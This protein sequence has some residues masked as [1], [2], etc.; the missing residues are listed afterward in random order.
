MSEGEFVE[1]TPHKDVKRGPQDVDES[2]D[3]YDTIDWLVKNIPHNNGKVGTY[4]ISYPGFYAAAGILDAH[5]AHKAASPQ[6][7]M[8]D[9]FMG[10]DSYHGG[11]FMLSANFGFYT[12]F[13]KR[14]EP[15]P[16][17]TRLPFDFKTPN[18]Y[19]FYL[20]MGSL[21]NGIENQMK[22]QSPYFNDTVKHWTY[23]EF[24]KSRALA[25]HIKNVKP[26]V[27]TVGGWFDHEDLAGPLTL[28]RA[29]GA[30]SPDTVNILVEGPWAHGGWSRGDGDVLGNVRFD[31]KTGVVF[32]DDIQFPF[33][34][35]YLK[36]KGDGKFP[37]AYVFETG[38]NVWR[39]TDAWPPKT[40]VSKS[41]YLQAGGKLDFRA[42]T[43][44]AN[45]FDE[46]VSDP[47][48]PV[49][50]TDALVTNVPGSYM[51]GDQRF[52]STRTDVM[53][54]QTDPLE[55]DMTIAGLISPRLFVSTSGTDSDW[56]VKL[57]DVYPN[58]YPDPEPNPTNVK[59]GGYQQLIR[60]EPL[61]G[62]FR[63]SMERPE[64][65]TPGKM[66]EIRF[67]M[68]DV[69]HTFRR[70]HRVMVQVQSSWFPLV[71]RNPQKF[72]NIPEAK[73]ADFSKATQRIYHSEAGPSGVSVS[74]VQ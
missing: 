36:G 74:V 20:K 31:V 2:T 49:P 61:R 17:Q 1:M 51:V 63:N 39:R 54:Y 35:Y 14:M 42:P 40:A 26:A 6:A 43:G 24:W 65:M 15:A 58:D 11:A 8:M 44:G 22:N 32:R 50:F 48:K 57:I 55:E 52:V 5:P 64:P 37:K 18:G 47:S 59:M 33:F 38:T 67:D 23:D 60:G 4:G 30:K 27:M 66:T 28:F 45:S 56:I 71:D 53:V 9:L 73:G 13:M 34:N 68:P 19:D 70:G 41:L 46:Y 10:D 72:T 16:P 12:G 25:P 3:T 29:I 7:P 69:F 62:K 21:E